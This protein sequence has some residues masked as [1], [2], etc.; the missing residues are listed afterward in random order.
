MSVSP[1]RRSSPPSAR[2]SSSSASSCRSLP[3]AG[4]GCCLSRWRRLTRWE[5]WPAWLF[6]LPVV[7]HGLWQ[8]L[9]YRHLTLFTAVN[10]GIPAGGFV[11]ESKSAILT[12][13]LQGAP[14]AP[15]ARFAS[16]DLPDA[17][18]ARLPSVQAAIRASGLDLPVVLKPDVGERGRGVAVVRSEAELAAYRAGLG[19][20][21][22]AGVRLRRGV[23]RLLHPPS[24]RSARPDLL[25][26]RQALPGLVVGDGR[27]RLEELILA[28]DR[29]VCMAAYYLEANLERLDMIPAPAER[30]QLVEIGNH[31]R[32]NGLPGST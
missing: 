32:G 7:L 11:E 15:I 14:G 25:D 3:G 9:R 28:D 26:H 22:R 20:V 6:E 10:P 24:R 13:P 12:G 5:F 2:P 4:A 21:D 18:E 1:C 29:A 19:P 30:V 17:E 23:R 27:R 16:I 8:G 31:C